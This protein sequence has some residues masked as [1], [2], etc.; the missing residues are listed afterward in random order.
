MINLYNQDCL[1]AMKRMDDN[2][3]DLAIVDPPYFSDYGRK[4]LYR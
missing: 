1:E 2:S 3:Y 4:K